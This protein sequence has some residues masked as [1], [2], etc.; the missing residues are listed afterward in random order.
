MPKFIYL[1]QASAESE[2]GA[3]P[4]TEIIQAMTDYNTQLS[5]ADMLLDGNGFRDS[6]AGA[7]LRFPT[8]GIDAAKVEVQKGPFA[9]AGLVCG[10]WIVQA[11]SFD[12]A[13]EW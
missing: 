6:S 13:V 4:S 11:K 1:L 5:K 8:G 9:L 10:Y 12:D 7:R 2:S 3:A